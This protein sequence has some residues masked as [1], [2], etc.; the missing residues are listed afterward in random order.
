MKGVFVTAPTALE[1]V[2]KI[3]SSPSPELS[4]RMRMDT[5]FDASPFVKVSVRFVAT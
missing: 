1:S 5:L 4:S 3:V 2:R